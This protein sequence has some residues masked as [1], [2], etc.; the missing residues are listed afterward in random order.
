MKPKKVKPAIY[1]FS[2]NDL[3]VWQ[4]APRGEF[5]EATWGWVDLKELA[6]II[7]MSADFL[8]Y[9]AFEITNGKLLHPYHRKLYGQPALAL[10]V[11]WHR[12]DI[13]N[14]YEIIYFKKETIFNDD[15]HTVCRQF[16]TKD[17]FV[18]AGWALA[19]LETFQASEKFYNEILRK[20]EKYGEERKNA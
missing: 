18:P 12:K 5:K 1:E 10:A 7:D 14:L 3:V 6:E 16:L 13:D 11:N 19:V 9:F 2:N 15:K 17:I 8:L 20:A 4:R